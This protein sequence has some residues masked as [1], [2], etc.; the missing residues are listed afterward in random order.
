MAHLETRPHGVGLFLE[1]REKH[2]NGLLVIR[3]DASGNPAKVT[4]TGSDSIHIQTLRYEQR[5]LLPTGVMFEEGSCV[6]TSA[7]ESCADELHFRMRIRVSQSTDE[8]TSDSVMETLLA[9]ESYC[10]CC[11]A[12][13][14][15]LLEDRV[16]QRVLPLPNG[17]WNAL[18]DEWCCHPD[19][20]A[21]RKLVPRADDCFLG[22]T[23]LLLARD[24]ACEH[25]LTEEV[26]PGGPVDNQD[27]KKPCRR[28]TV[29]TCTSCSSVLGEAVGAETLRLYVTQVAVELA[30]GDRKPDASLSRCLFLER[31]MAARLLKLSNTQTTFRFSVETPDGKTFMLLWLLNSDSII[32]ALAETHVGGEL[33]DGS[34]DLHNPS[35]RAAR[36]LKLLYISCSETDVL[37]RDIIA[38]WEVTVIGHP[39]VLPL[40]VCEELLQVMED[41]NSSLPA[42]MRFMTSYRVA[43]LRL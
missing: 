8:G 37:Q 28:L 36:A 12:C 41:S 17:N 38:R 15:R 1:V 32:A 33:P 35:P 24:G 19:P 11:Q 3:K 43:Y 10:F 25:T 5:L 16:F 39:V 7:G 22:D 4:V 14:T 27:P 40:N 9:K 18:V 2:Q 13:S 34:P 20:F 29:L 21:N 6:Q 23:F 42:S 31:T 30:V 26:S